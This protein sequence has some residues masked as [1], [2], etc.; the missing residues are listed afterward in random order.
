MGS[1]GSRLGLFREGRERWFSELEG[2]Q[3][4]GL[5]GFVDMENGFKQSRS[6]PENLLL[7]LD[8]VGSP[9]LDVLPFKDG[10]GFVFER[11]SRRLL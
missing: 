1:S 3:A 8:G 9:L 7:F 10:E 2:E 4:T 11:P 6:K 5:K